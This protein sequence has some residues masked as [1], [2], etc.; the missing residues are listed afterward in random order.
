[1][2]LFNLSS[3]PAPGCLPCS[4]DP[5]VL[6]LLYSACVSNI[7]LG[8]QF[9][10][11]TTI[12]FS[13]FC[14]ILPALSLFQHHSCMFYFIFKVVSVLPVLFYFPSLPL[15]VVL[16]CCLWSCSNYTA[17][18]LQLVFRLPFHTVQPCCFDCLHLFILAGHVLCAISFILS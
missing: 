12:L 9:S 18:L 6:R 5:P 15:Q 3:A 2:E 4:L 8:V 7:M 13:L 10:V 11:D 17:A 16:F 14:Y 1:M